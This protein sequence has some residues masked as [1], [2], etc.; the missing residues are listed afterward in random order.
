MFQSEWWLNAACG[1]TCE[2][3]ET[4]WDGQL[5]GVLPYH[6]TRRL[7]LVRLRMPPYTRTL[8][9]LLAPPPSKPYQ[10][11]ANQRRIVRALVE[12]LPRF[13]SFEQALEPGDESA[14]A[15]LVAGFPATQA[16]T[17]RI[18][19]DEPEALIWAGLDKK[20][21]NI[22]R[23]TA[24]RI[25]VQDS[26]DFERYL[27]LSRAECRPGGSTHDFPT[28]ERLFQA[29][30]SRGQATLR[31]AT[32]DDGDMAVAILLWGG[33]TLY[34]WVVARAWHSTAAGA[35]TLLIWDAIR[36]AQAR[37]LTF[38]FDGYCSAASA[39]FLERFGRTAVVRPVIGRANAV[40]AGAAWAARSIET[41]R[42]NRGTKAQA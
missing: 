10:R 17:Y 15:F 2:R 13:D 27:R 33:R 24:T 19:P 3:V 18:A 40:Y 30:A 23:T 34:Y 37:G 36:F 20:V 41:I 39:T 32:G 22:I 16:Y 8:G 31:C 6:R 1:G 4:V 25:E 7:G 5:V 11:H 26:R 29:A 28:L 35:N 38:D 42:P 12:Q 14:P 21:R 9:P